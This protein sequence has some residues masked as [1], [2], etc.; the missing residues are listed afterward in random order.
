M[1]NDVLPRIGPLLGQVIPLTIGAALLLFAALHDIAA[2]TIPNWISACLA[3]LGLALRLVEHQLLAGLALG[4]VVFAAAA[5]CWQRGW[6]GGGDVKLLGAVA[7]FVTP[8]QVG[9]LLEATTLAGGVI[10]LI[11][12]FSRLALRHK[13]RGVQPCP[14]QPRPIQ[15]R[16]IQPR[17]S[18]LL[19]RIA[20]AELRRLRRGTSLPYASAIAAG[21][22]FVMFTG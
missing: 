14:T 13:A 18:G 16:P 10:G 6:M 22:F 4:I 8:G 7:I 21:A 11:Y 17:S 1:S 20:R 9:V 5:F 12:L 15:P 19:A 2:R 3:L